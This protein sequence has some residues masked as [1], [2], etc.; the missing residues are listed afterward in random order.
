M[1]FWHN[2]A[3]K[4]TKISNFKTN[5]TTANVY[6]CNENVFTLT[7]NATEYSINEL[8]VPLSNN[9]YGPGYEIV[10][11]D[12]AEYGGKVTSSVTSKTDV[13]LVS[14]DKQPAETKTARV[15]YHPPQH[16]EALCIVPYTI[17]YS[18]TLLV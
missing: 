18:I 9:Y 4:T 2:S 1:N 13:V 14:K 3:L 15:T 12:G 10:F 16:P 17:Y 5:I 8:T 7:N 6:D 11:E